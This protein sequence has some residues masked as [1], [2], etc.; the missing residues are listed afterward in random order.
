MDRAFNRPYVTGAPARVPT[1][2]NG[3]LPGDGP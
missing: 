3:Q 1:C 2:G